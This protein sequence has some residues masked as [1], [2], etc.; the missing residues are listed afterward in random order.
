MHLSKEE[1]ETMLWIDEIKGYWIAE[2][3]IQKD[4][5]KFRKQGWEEIFVWTDDNKC[6][7]ARFKA[8][9]FA[10]SIRKPQKREISDERKEA[11]RERMKKMKNDMN[12]R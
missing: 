1:K 10:V 7:R 9:R 12:L 4:I 8:P 2:T 6:Y 5:T 3:S 11:A